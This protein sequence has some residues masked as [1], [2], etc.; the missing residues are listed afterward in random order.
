MGALLSLVS[1][2]LLPLF[3]FGSVIS[4]RLMDQ[5]SKDKNR[6]TYKL[7]FP[8]EFTADMVIAALRGLTGS[9]RQRSKILDGYPTIAFELR[10]TK[11]GHAWYIRAPWGH[12]PEIQ[13]SLRAQIPGLTIQ[14]VSPPPPTAW[15]AAVEVAMTNMDRPLSIGTQPGMRP[16]DELVRD[17][18][19]AGPFADGEMLI[20]Q[21]IATPAPTTKKPLPHEATSTDSYLVKAMRGTLKA[22]RDEV[23][24]RRDKITEKNFLVSMRIGAVAETKA[25]AH[26]IINAITSAVKSTETPST[27]FN[28]RLLTLRTLQDRINRAA[29][30]FDYKMQLTATE[31]AAM[32]AWPVGNPQ[33]PGMPAI[34]GR[35]ML[36]PENVPQ[37]GRVLGMNIFGDLQR[38]VAQPYEEAVKH[39]WVLGASGSGKTTLLGNM[40]K[41]DMVNGYGVVMIESKG[42]LFYRALDFVPRERLSDVIVVNVRDDAMPVGFNILSQ[43]GE[44]AVNI[45]EIMQMFRQL[46][47]NGDDV[48]M[49]KLMYQAL[50][51][52]ATQPGMT[53]VDLEWLLAPTTPEEEGK[54]A[55]VIESLSDERH[56]ELRA[57]WTSFDQNAAQAQKTMLRPVLD[58]IWQ[59]TDRPELRYIFGQ[60]ES[61]FDMAEV[62]RDNKILL[63]NFEG[64]PKESAAIAGS[65]MTTALYNAVKTVKSPT[66]TFLYLDEFQSFLNIPGD[67]EDMLAKARS[68]NLGMVLAHQH[69][70]QLPRSMERAVLGNVSTKIVLQANAHDANAIKFEFGD[71]VKQED[72]TRI[73]RYQAITRVATPSGVS[74]PFTMTTS[75][76]A[77]GTGMARQVVEQSRQR[78]GRPKQEVR[79]AMTARRKGAERV[80]RRSSFNDPSKRWGQ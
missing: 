24:E 38:P 43:G 29:G 55:E 42:D 67:A 64:M 3:I 2:L 73:G 77:K 15:T 33:V 5:K 53:F 16:V 32:I 47:P 20:V 18:L 25:K 78:Y 68:F 39:T 66:P 12:E 75:E 70:D 26:K 61:T 19:N 36:V 23:S 28:R 79:A 49:R 46:Y 48:W 1:V 9:L 41:Q 10:T 6:K 21:I 72:F 52:L 65:L 58:R 54:R 80:A 63:V 56:E 34:Q 35:Q 27:H 69:I 11:E 51:T 14:A 37:D 44:A 4:V 7:F 40:I 62:I 13:R 8:G 60:S 17:L 71:S 74:Q 76:P 45:D 50:R 59:I 31:L 22:D 30:S 57:F